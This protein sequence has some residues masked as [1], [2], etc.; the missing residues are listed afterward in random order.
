MINV[1]KTI[2]SV[3]VVNELA[4]VGYKEGNND[5]FKRGN[6]KIVVKGNNIFVNDTPTSLEDTM[7]LIKSMK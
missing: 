1:S 3:F 7:A 6:T 4:F 2:Y 5:V